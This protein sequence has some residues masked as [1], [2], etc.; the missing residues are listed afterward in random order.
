LSPVA[1]RRA[2]RSLRAA[3]GELALRVVLAGV[4]EF[5]EL[6]VLGELDVLRLRFGLFAT[7]VSSLCTR[8]CH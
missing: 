2:V 7:D 8:F 4:V 1:P 3:F 6:E 5:A